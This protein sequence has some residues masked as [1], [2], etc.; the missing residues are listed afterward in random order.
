[1][2]SASII[3]SRDLIE[4][5]IRGMM[6]ASVVWSNAKIGWYNHVIRRWFDLYSRVGFSERRL[7]LLGLEMDVPAKAAK[8]KDENDVFHLKALQDSM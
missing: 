3:G 2:M 6:N 8:K 1:M 4:R 7:C 5:I